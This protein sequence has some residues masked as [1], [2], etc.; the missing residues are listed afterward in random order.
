[1]PSNAAETPGAFISAILSAYARRG[2]SAD[3]ALL[4]AQIR[5]ADLLRSQARVTA[6]QME[7]FSGFAMRELDDEGLGLF[8]RRLPWGSTGLLCRAS[9]T[10][11]NLRVALLRWCRHF[12]L[13]VDDI[14]LELGVGGGVARLTI[15][16]HRDLGEQREFGLVTHLR[17]AHGFACW[18]VDSRIQLHEASFPFAAPPHVR[19]YG[20]MFPGRLRFDQPQAGIAF[21]AA[22]LDL[23]IRREDKDLRQ[24]LVRPLLLAVHQY[25]RDRLLSQ[26]IRQLLKSRGNELSNADALASAL[27]VSVRSLF[28]QLADEGSSLQSLKDEVR[29][30]I[31]MEQ[32][33]RT[34]RSL[35]QVAASAGFRNEA[36]FN[37]AFRQWTGQTPGEFRRTAERTAGL[38][39]TRDP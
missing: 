16:E 25:R 28:R 8:S 34:G 6:L 26:Q 19:A 33:T 37:R 15:A 32:L 39:P 35:K 31:A 4:A 3:A 7:Q 21:D 11:P 23:P 1:M 14:S 13:L 10:A 9:L 22:Y 5:P 20:H 18:L 17:N 36:S 2:V 29:R 24:L 12:A 30:E 27:N 38:Q